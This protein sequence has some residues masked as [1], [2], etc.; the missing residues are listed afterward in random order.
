MTMVPTGREASLSS[1]G[2]TQWVQPPMEVSRACEIWP[3]GLLSFW[4][5]NFTEGMHRRLTSERSWLPTVGCALHCSLVPYTQCLGEER[6][7][8]YAYFSYRT[9]AV[10]K[11]G[12]AFPL[13]GFPAV[14]FCMVLIPVEA[15]TG[16]LVSTPLQIVLTFDGPIKVTA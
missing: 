11:Y 8:I 15:S 9:W 7:Y 16:Y 13:V 10:S 14:C 3:R 12:G 6:W 4:R 1:R 5:T 2:E